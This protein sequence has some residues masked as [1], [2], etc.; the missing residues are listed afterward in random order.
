MLSDRLIE[1][2]YDLE[3]VLRFLVLQLLA[4]GE[5]EFGTLRDFSQILDDEFV[6]LATSHPDGDP[7][8][9]GGLQEDV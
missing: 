3:L 4:D 9:G 5:I 6:S 8:L 1:E 7:N 2:R